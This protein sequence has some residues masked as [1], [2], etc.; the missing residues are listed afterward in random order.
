MSHRFTLSLM[1]T[2]GLVL[3]IYPLLAGFVGD[4]AT[5]DE[6]LSRSPERGGIGLELQLNVEDAGRSGSFI[7][8]RLRDDL[9]QFDERLSIIVTDKRTTSAITFSE[10]MH[11]LACDMRV[12]RLT[13]F[14]RWWE[15]A[16]KTPDN[17]FCNSATQINGFP[18]RCPRDENRQ[19]AIDPF[20][21]TDAC[22]GY[23][24]IAFSNR[25]DLADKD[26]G[27]HCGEYRIVFAKN[28]GLGPEQNCQAGLGER[29]LIIFEALLPN[30]QP[31]RSPVKPTVNNMF[32][33][34]AGC[35]PIVEFW[36]SLS[37]AN[38]STTAR[39]AALHD[40][41]LKGLPRDGIGPVVDA[42]NYAGGPAS[43]QI[44]TNQLMQPHWTLREFKT[45]GGSIVPSSVKSNP[46]NALFL[47]DPRKIELADYL[48]RKD[49]LDFLRGLKSPKGAAGEMS[50]F[51]FAFGLTAP[52]LDHL[53]S[54]ES[55]AELP[56]D[57]DVSQAF[58]DCHNDPK[59][60][61]SDP[62]ERKLK[63][64]LAKEKSPLSSDNI[65][66]RIRAQ[67][68][69]GCH[70]YSD[71]DRELKVA[72]P[73]GWPDTLCFVR[74]KEHLGIWPSTLGGGP[75]RKGFTHV[76]EMETETG[77]EIGVSNFANL[78]ITTPGE[79]RSIRPDR[80][81]RL[82]YMGPDGRNSR[83]RISETLKR[84]LMPPRFDNMVLYLNQFDAPH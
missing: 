33:N 38:M 78:E 45:Y 28:T 70:H 16:K 53:N 57:G 47:E 13:L 3:A 1:N 61:D 59:C 44:R 69:A 42:K 7:G 66:H 34:L 77:E 32:V 67:T 5:A 4:A 11:N 18:Y 21:S 63:E 19:A 50:V 24:A 22:D 54:F 72:C 58:D 35:R 26:R 83:Y 52:G 80:I 51:T 43:G 68:C 10:V 40:F 6:L 37:D 8:N 62:I 41:Y 9:K 2:L 75:G 48:I 60:R 36:R 20:D 27:Q 65:V 82:S 76:S 29:N 25:F 14:R 12:D 31:P 17:V 73:D 23:T 46:G 64:E 79:L 55:D 71:G 39:G 81:S 84:V 30:P 15:T 74:D 49:A 56:S